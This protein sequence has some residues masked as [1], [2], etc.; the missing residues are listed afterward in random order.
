M[1][2][3]REIEISGGSGF[4][5]L[6]GYGAMKARQEP[7]ID[8]LNDLD[9]SDIL[10]NPILDIAARFW[11]AERYQAFRVCYR[12]MRAVDNLVDDR[13][14]TGGTMTPRE[15]ELYRGMILDWMTSL[16]RGE[17]TDGFQA[18]LLDTL[19]RFHIPLWPWERLAAAMVYDLEHDGFRSFLKFLRY[20][21]G[22]AIAPASV[23]MHLCGVRNSAG[24]YVR[25]PFDIRKVA[26]PLAVFSYLV[27][28]MR[29]F[30]Q[31]TQHG[32]VYF[33]D[34]I[35]AAHGLSG[36]ALRNLSSD[37][38]P[39]PSL[40]GLMADY[41]RLA[42]FYRVEARFTM[43][44]LLTNLPD[45]YRL[46]VEIIYSLYLQI[47]ERVDPAAGTFATDELNPQPAEVL[48]RIKET[49]ASFGKVE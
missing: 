7:Q 30:R 45:R 25:P 22:A 34:D 26:R 24:G 4:C 2:E 32:L 3:D 44:R 8:F 5:Y 46:S 37:E 29:D 11:E 47:L 43:D 42:E 16:R 10:T 19:Q 9:F 12:S 18:E 33:A 31:D 21:E 35:M 13:K 49:V 39:R 28:I 40:R 27:H 41:R 6:H 48:A 1:V 14:A 17:R 36:A 20:C 38:V 15:R 23:F